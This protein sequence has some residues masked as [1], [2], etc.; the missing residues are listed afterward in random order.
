MY[1]TSRTSRLAMLGA[2]VVLIG[3][4]LWTLVS[5]PRTYE[6]ELSD[7]LTVMWGLMLLGGGVICLAA[8]LARRLLWET[9]G[10]VLAIGGVVIYA[11]L[12]WQQIL[13][14]TWGSGVRG[15]LLIWITL[16]LVSRLADASRAIR[17]A[18]I[19]E[20]RRHREGS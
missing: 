15:M 16:I 4:G 13:T 18:R 11:V 12:S 14:G 9:P 20:A 17:E 2:C 3:A 1:P 6:S 19:R 7:A 5:P 8:H 10:L